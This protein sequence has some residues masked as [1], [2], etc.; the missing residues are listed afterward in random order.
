MITLAHTTHFG[1]PRSTTIQLK[2]Y[3]EDFEQIVGNLPFLKNRLESNEPSRVIRNITHRVRVCMQAFP[4]QRNTAD[5]D[6]RLN[7]LQIRPNSRIQRTSSTTSSYSSLKSTF[8]SMM[9]VTRQSMHTNTSTSKTQALR[10]PGVVGVVTSQQDYFAPLNTLLSLR[11]TRMSTL[12]HSHQD[13]FYNGS[14]SSALGK[15]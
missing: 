5:D 10:S 13:F 8:R 1:P 11:Q 2:I 9:T 15:S 3:T 7:R 14:C 6:F 4:R 12:T